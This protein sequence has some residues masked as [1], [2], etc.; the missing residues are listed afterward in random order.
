MKKSVYIIVV[1][2]LLIFVSA[3]SWAVW[4]EIPGLKITEI[5][6]GHDSSSS[7]ER[8]YYFISFNKDL[9]TEC[10]S[11]QVVVYSE[12]EE[13]RSRLFSMAL[14]AMISG[15][16]VDF[17]RQSGCKIGLTPVDAIKVKH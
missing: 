7:P 11:R 16:D 2:A 17:Y 4:S 5:H 1:Q 13:R 3:P 12:S 14:A 10:N 15:K 9:N 6:S 8:L